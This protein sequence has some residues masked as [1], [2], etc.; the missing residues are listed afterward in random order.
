MPTVAEHIQ[1]SA[2]ERRLLAIRSLDNELSLAN[3]SSCAA[4]LQAMVAADSARPLIASADI[5]GLV[6]A[7]MLASVA[8]GWD[9]VALVA[10]S[11]RLLLHPSVAGG[12][13]LD[14]FGVDV[15]SPTFDNV[16]NH[17]VLFGERRLQAQAVREAFDQ[18]DDAVR[19]AAQERLLAVPGLWAHTQ[20]CYEDAER[21][22]SAK[23]KYPLGT[24]QLLLALL[25]AAGIGPKFFDRQY[26]PWLVANC[27][28]GVETYRKYAFNAAVWWPALAGAVGPASHTEQIYQRI[29]NMRPHDFMDA[30]NRLDRERRAAV[31]EKEPWLDDEWNIIDTRRTTLMATLGWLV[32][33]TG[34]RDPVRDGLESI[35]TWEERRIPDKE[36]ALVYI[37]GPHFKATNSDPD[38]A[39]AN[40][41]G[42]CNAL[43][44]NFYLGGESG[45]RFNWVGGSCW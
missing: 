36:R 14:L 13:P 22:D 17:V 33:L 24:A 26:L 16:S 38:T 42:A 30:V 37:G 43:N 40:V 8:P 21:I 35:A 32:N 19:Q 28:G 23:Y 15:F 44:A 25:E 6:S 41:R 12:R 4:R 5:D 34:W 18:W 27:D 1:T 11:D 7:T 3:P 9:V 10:D 29:Q 20:G 31:P 45:S 2:P 39:A